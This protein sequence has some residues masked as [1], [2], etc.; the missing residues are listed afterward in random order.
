MDDAGG[1]K[2]PSASVFSRN[3]S[4]QLYI[5]YLQMKSTTRDSISAF[6]RF[7]FE[8]VRAFTLYGLKGKYLAAVLCVFKSVPFGISLP[9]F[10]RIALYNEFLS[11]YDNIIEKELRCDEIEDGIKKS[12]RPVIVD[13]GINLGMT[14]R[15]WFSLNK[16][17]VVYGIDMIPESLEFTTG[18]LKTIPGSFNWTGIPSAVSDKKQ[19]FTIQYDDPLEG[20]NSVFSSAGKIKRTVT[21]D[22]LDNLLKQYAPAEIDLIKIDIEGFGAV[23]LRGGVELLSKCRYIIL[24]THTPEEISEANRILINLGWD[25]FLVKGRSAFYRNPALLSE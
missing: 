22:T 10:G 9:P 20:S 12:A 5:F 4:E 14:V 13:L 19:S 23:A 16:N 11:I 21:A 25:L 8:A 6:L 15:W 7:P 17:A 3:E 1:R 2:K 18:R 24:E